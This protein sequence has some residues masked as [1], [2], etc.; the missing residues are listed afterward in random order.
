MVAVSEKLDGF[1]PV[2]VILTVVAA[3]CA[4]SYKVL[5]KRTVGDAGDAFH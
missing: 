3:V 2:G 1:K 4:A 5:L